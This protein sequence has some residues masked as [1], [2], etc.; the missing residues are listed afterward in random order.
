MKFTQTKD[1]IKTTA[2]ENKVKSAVQSFNA[3]FPMKPAG[4]A[5]LMK[6]GKQTFI[7]TSANA[8]TYVKYSAAAKTERDSIERALRKLEARISALGA[9]VTVQK[10][11]TEAEKR[12]K[13]AAK[14]AASKKRASKS[15][16]KAKKK[17]KRS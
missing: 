4:D 7:R 13:A 8:K 1:A 5:L 17:G 14:A 10:D 6:R 2:A 11:V 3:A 12:K 16:S 9:K 15:K